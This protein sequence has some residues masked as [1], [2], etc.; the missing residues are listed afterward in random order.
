MKLNLESFLLV[1]N[2]ALLFLDSLDMISG[3]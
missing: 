3:S 2:L 1:K